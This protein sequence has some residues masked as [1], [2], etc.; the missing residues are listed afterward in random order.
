MPTL[1][2]FR[3]YDEKNVINF[4]T[5]S[6]ETLPF[7]KGTLV[8]IQGT[9][10]F[11][12]DLEPVEFLG[13]FGDF[14]VGNTVA[15]RYGATPKVTAAGTGDNPIGMTL[16]D[17]R[18]VDENGLPL[19]YNPRKAAEMEAV[20]SGQ[21]V[22]IVTK[23]TFLYSGVVGTITPG[24]PAYLGPNGTIVTGIGT[25]TGSTPAPTKV[26][27]FLGATGVDGSCLLWLNITQ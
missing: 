1:R 17:V 10:G 15:Q 5:L 4:Y 26:G 2:P 8:K 6:G 24:A 11:R 23:G 27:K 3:D 25:L 13:S 12:A 7:N 14:T 21:V 18:E 9:Q 16:F 20:I 19:K 22:P